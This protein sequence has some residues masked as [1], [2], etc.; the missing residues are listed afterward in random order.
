[1]LVLGSQHDAL[2]ELGGT[3]DEGQQREKDGHRQG[4]ETSVPVRLVV[5][6]HE[7]PAEN[8]VPGTL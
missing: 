6:T 7:P 4:P 2:L 1:M 5:A 3:T 8:T